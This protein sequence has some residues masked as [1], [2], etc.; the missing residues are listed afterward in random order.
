MNSTTTTFLCSLTTRKWKAW[1]PAV[2]GVSFAVS[3]LLASSPIIHRL[4]YCTGENDCDFRLYYLHIALLLVGVVAYG[5]H[6]PESLITDG[7]FD[8]VG[9]S[10]NLMHILT[11]LGMTVKF[12]F[13]RAEMLRRKESLIHLGEVQPTFVLSFSF[14]LVILLLNLATARLVGTKRRKE[15]ESEGIG[16][17]EE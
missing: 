4:L 17:K 7:T 10:H 16:R 12:E 11:A 8:F 1:R 2:L 5:T 13:V 9:N 3:Y 6:V 14:F 15:E